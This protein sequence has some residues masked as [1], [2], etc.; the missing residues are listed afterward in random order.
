MLTTTDIAFLERMQREYNSLT[1]QWREARP[2]SQEVA[3][4]NATF[5]ARDAELGRAVVGGLFTRM[6]AHVVNT[7]DG[8]TR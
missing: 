7:P 5:K 2:Y 4:L 8:E 6:L 3:N 1:E